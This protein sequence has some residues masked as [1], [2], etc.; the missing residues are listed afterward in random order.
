MKAWQRLDSLRDDARFRG[1]MARIVVNCAKDM[2]R[3]RK[4]HTVELTDTIPAPQVEDAHLDEAMRLLDERLRLPIALY[5]MEGLSVKEVAEVLG[6]PQG[7]VKN[8]MHRGRERLAAL[9][10]EEVEG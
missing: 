4:A 8:R 3:K 6:L 2:L 9:L 10:G 5:Y 7:T 1:W